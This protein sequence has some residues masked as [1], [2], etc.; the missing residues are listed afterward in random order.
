MVSTRET[1]KMFGISGEFS[2]DSA[3]NS[4]IFQVI[5][6]AGRTTNEYDQKVACNLSKEVIA[7]L[8]KMQLSNE[9]EKIEQAENCIEHVLLSSPYRNTA[10][11]FILARDR[12]N[13]AGEES[14][15]SEIN[16]VDISKYCQGIYIS[17][18]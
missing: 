3:L 17:T 18:R 12:R 6:E 10:K 8:W 11:V 14:I 9:Q 15:K 16:R 1:K 2:T 7:M 4:Q 5:A 13:R